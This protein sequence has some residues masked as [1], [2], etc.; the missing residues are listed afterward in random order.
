[1]RGRRDDAPPSA[2][3]LSH[4]VRLGASVVLQVLR[5]ERRELRLHR[6][7]RRDG[8]ECLVRVR[9]D[10]RHDAWRPRNTRAVRPRG[11][12]TRPR[13]GLCAP[14]V[15]VRGGK[16]SRSFQRK[17]ARLFSARRAGPRHG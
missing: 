13:V 9:H 14:A 1:M 5:D 15:P 4:L 7:I 16:R 10:A 11:T 12:G 17:L 3:L 8:V 6:L 2:R